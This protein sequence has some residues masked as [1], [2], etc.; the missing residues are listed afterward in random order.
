MALL[1]DKNPTLMATESEVPDGEVDTR[2][3]LVDVPDDYYVSEY[4]TN[5]TASSIG[6]QLMAPFVLGVISGKLFDEGHFHAV[7][8]FGGITFVFS[9][10][11][12]SLAKPLHQGVGMGIGLGFCFV[13]TVGITVHHFAKRK[14]LA[15][16]VA[17]SGGAVGSTVFPISVECALLITDCSHLI[18]KIG[19]GA[20]VRATGYIVLVFVIGGNILMRTR[21]PPRSKQ[22]NAAAP[23]VKK[24][25]AMLASLGMTFPLV[26]IQLY[27][28]RHS[29][30]SN[31]S[32]IHA[33]GR[34]A[35]NHLADIYGPLNVQTW[36]TFITGGL[37]WAVLGI[38]NTWSLVLVSVLYGIFSGAC[39]FQN[40]RLFLQCAMNR[41]PGLALSFGCLASFA[42][43]TNEVGYHG[44][45]GVSPIQGALLTPS[46]FWIR[47]AAFSGSLMF[48]GALL[49]GV[50]RMVQSKEKASQIV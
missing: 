41:F 40:P 6:F 44:I 37:I 13:P 35:G 4:L 46:F 24:N 48:A 39:T 43:S 38:H 23:N 34:V 2:Q 1:S 18:P 5:H 11:M 29:V 21:L 50:G 22:P 47:P 3:N 33:F 7:E 15:S 30:G 10:F 20:A 9:V 36:C 49:V 8:I 17:L 26:Y 16:G 14:G 19:F 28:T 27:A 45:S 31:I 12:L 25:S 42:R 32:F